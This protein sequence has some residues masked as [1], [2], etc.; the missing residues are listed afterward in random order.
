MTT[1]IAQIENSSPKS[2]PREGWEE[3]LKALPKEEFIL[4]DEDK[5]WLN[6]D[7]AGHEDWT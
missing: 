7:F 5:E 6:A 4:T 3:A 2:N 1:R